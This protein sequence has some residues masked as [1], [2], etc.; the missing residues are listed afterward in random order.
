M[1]LL[2]RPEMNMHYGKIPYT[3][4]AS[5]I[6]F[7]HNH[8]PLLRFSQLTAS[9]IRKTAPYTTC[10]RVVTITDTAILTRVRQQLQ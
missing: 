8:F 6:Y 9:R 5:S 3:Y 7:H 10:K 1:V 4:C 2:L